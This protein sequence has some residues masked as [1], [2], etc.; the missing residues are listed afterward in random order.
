MFDVELISFTEPPAPPSV[1]DDLQ[2]PPEDA[3]RTETGLIYRMLSPGDGQS[4]PTATATVNVHYS[5]WM[6]SNG[7]L[8]DSSVM[9]GEPISFGLNQ[10]I[11]G[12]TEGLQLM[13]VGEKARLDSWASRV[14]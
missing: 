9:R 3:V 1:P 10:V 5:G 11:A 4:S 7:E 8:F 6:A 2:T 12:W 13:T 14:W